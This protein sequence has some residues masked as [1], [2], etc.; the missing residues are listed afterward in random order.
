MGAAP[1]PPTA[2]RQSPSA[3]EAL[4]PGKAYGASMGPRNRARSWSPDA[5][6][7]QIFSFDFRAHGIETRP[8]TWT[9]SENYER[10]EPRLNAGDI[11]LLDDHTLVEQL[12]TLVVRGSKVEHEPGGHLDFSA[13]AVG[14]LNL[15]LSG[16]GRDRDISE[17]ICTVP[18]P[19]T[20][21]WAEE[22]SELLPRNLNVC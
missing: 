1:R 22:G 3:Q 9:E 6:G 2:P 11:D 19:G 17:L 12:L 21:F 8:S 10:L 15:A 7:G 18:G 13:A 5:Y 4:S 16:R 14:A 20:R